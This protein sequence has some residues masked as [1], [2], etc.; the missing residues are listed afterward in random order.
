MTSRSRL[1]SDSRAL[2]ASG[3]GT[4]RWMTIA[5]ARN[6]ANGV[7]SARSSGGFPLQLAAAPVA[8]DLSIGRERPDNDRT[9]V[10]DGQDQ[11]NRI[12]AAQRTSLRTGA[13]RRR[14]ITLSAQGNAAPQEA[15][16]PSG[17][18]SILLVL[19]DAEPRSTDHGYGIAAHVQI[20]SPTT[21]SASRRDRSYPGAPSHGTSAGWIRAEW[22]MTENNRRARRSPAD[23]RRSEAA[24]G[25][26]DRG[27]SSPKG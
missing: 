10:A 27:I 14:R 7:P 19:T 9:A 16:R 24:R 23:A 18:R 8:A 6:T 12:R 11:G 3:P 26:A 4:P 13:G 22:Q 17:A 20:D 5:A 2:R 1:P 21:S 25:R 15:G